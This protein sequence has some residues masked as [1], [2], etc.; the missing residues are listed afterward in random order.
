[1]ESSAS[2][3]LSATFD[4][5]GLSGISGIGVGGSVSWSWSFL[6]PVSDIISFVDE[7]SFEFIENVLEHINTA[8]E[9]PNIQIIDLYMNILLELLETKE[10][11]L[12]KA[13]VPKI[14]MPKIEIQI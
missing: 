3:F 13:M 4:D 1:M 7:V 8:I 2:F 5:K 10:P 12:S 9:Q 6:I 11:D 14:D